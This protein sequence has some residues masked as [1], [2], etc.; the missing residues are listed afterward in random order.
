M[1][2]IKRV[3]PYNGNPNSNLLR[4]GRMSD[5]QLILEKIEA[6]LQ[7]CVFPLVVGDSDMHVGDDIF[8]CNP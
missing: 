6:S 4:N 8:F 2:S 1:N 3:V 5:R 7:N